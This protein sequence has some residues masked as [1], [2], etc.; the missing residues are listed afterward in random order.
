[1]KKGIDIS[2]HNGTINMKKVKDSG[3]EFIILQLGYG[4][5]KSQIDEKFY[6]N[7]KKATEL[8]IPIGVYLYSYA[9]NCNDALQEAKLVIEQIKNLKI[10]Y[11]IFFDMEDVDDYKVRNGMQSN[12]TLVDI[13]ETF[14]SYV[15]NAGYYVGIYASLDWLNNKLNDKKLDRFD[16]WVAQWNNKCSYKKEYGMWQYS[17]TGSI[18]GISGNVDLDYAIKDYPTIIKNAGLNKISSNEVIYIVQAGDNI[19]KI[20]KKYNTNWEN[21]YKLN[22]N[23]IGND[24]NFIKAGQQLVIKEEK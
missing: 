7:Y 16:K 3:I 9:L 8:N 17:S 15:E 6:E 23:V 4:K 14:C 19:T 21:I 2:K 24:P 5:N 18:D 1:M 11:P 22:K 13:C 10:E 20:A 12:Q